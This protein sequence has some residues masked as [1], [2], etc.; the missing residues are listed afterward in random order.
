MNKLVHPQNGKHP[1][2]LFENVIILQNS[3]PTAVLGQ[4]IFYV[5]HRPEY[6]SVNVYKY[7]S[8]LV[9]SIFYPIGLSLN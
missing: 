1:R 6:A 2:N 3:P 9:D 4:M 8:P 5:W 7:H